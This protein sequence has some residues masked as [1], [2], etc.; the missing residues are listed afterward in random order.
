MASSALVPPAAEHASATAVAARSIRSASSAEQDGREEQAG[1]SS[2]HETEIVATQSGSHAVSIERVTAH[3]VRCSHECRREGLKE[4]RD[5]TE[6]A[7]QITADATAQRE[8][9]Q[10]ERDD[11]EEQGDQDEGEHESRQVVVLARPEELRR[12][13]GRPC[14]ISLGV[15]RVGSHDMRA[16]VPAIDDRACAPERP[17][18]ERCCAWNALRGDF[19]EVELI[20]RV[21][22]DCA[23]EEGEEDEEAGTENED[24]RNET[25]ERS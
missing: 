7:G 11:G 20:G 3:D 17:V 12:D 19:D 14:K 6:D 24:Q 25:Q 21:V 8:Q 4:E 23:A 15:E 2:P 1:R 16:R 13:T 18:R 10:E 22:I 9:A 5:R